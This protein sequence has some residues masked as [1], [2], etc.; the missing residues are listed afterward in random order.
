MCMFVCTSVSERVG[1]CV[2]SFV[3]QTIEFWCVSVCAGVCAVA[4]AGGGC[5]LE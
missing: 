1:S 2:Y 4:C 3:W 5:T